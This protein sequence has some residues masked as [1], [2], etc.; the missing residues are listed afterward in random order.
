MAAYME[1]GEMGENDN[2]GALRVGCKYKPIASRTN[3]QPNQRFIEPPAVVGMENTQ[4]RLQK[5][6]ETKQKYLPCFG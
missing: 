5:P 4:I 3:Y 6:L 1:T 2:E